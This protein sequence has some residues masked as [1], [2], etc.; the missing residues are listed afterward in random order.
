VKDADVSNVSATRGKDVPVFMLREVEA[1]TV[2]R[3]NGV[4]DTHKDKADDEKL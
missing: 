3:V 2:H 4:P 1:F